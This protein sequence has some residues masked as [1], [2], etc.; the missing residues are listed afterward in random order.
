MVDTRPGCLFVDGHDVND[1]SLAELRSQISQVLQ[2]SFLFGEPLYSNI[3]YDD[4]ERSLELI[5]DAAESASF[6]IGRAHV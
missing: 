1:Y 5:W 3:S 4:P 6:Q 2:D